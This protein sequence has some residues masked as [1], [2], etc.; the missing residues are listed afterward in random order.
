MQYELV[1]QKANDK[2]SSKSNSLIIPYFPTIL[3]PSAFSPNNDVWKAYAGGIEQVTIDVYNLWGQ[4]LTQ[5]NHFTWDGK[6]NKEPLPAGTYIFVINATA[7]TGIQ[8]HKTELVQ[9]IK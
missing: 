9:L 2:F 1:A 8:I 4:K 5:L 7:N 3:L 6:I